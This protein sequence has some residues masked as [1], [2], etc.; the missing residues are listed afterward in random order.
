[1]TGGNYMHK[2][3]SAKMFTVYSQN[4]VNPETPLDDSYVVGGIEY[5]NLGGPLGTKN[6]F[7]VYA[8]LGSEFYIASQEGMR[9]ISSQSYAD[10]EINAGRNLVLKGQQEVGIEA[11]GGIG[12]V[13]IV[14]P[15][16]WVN[17]EGYQIVDGVGIGN[18]T[19]LIR[20]A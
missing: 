12:P 2:K 1:L 5:E 16:F 3:V 18:T 4:F 7:M 15:V 11:Q 14:N 13:N 6:I 17:G 8:S 20:T 9:I 10:I 19:V